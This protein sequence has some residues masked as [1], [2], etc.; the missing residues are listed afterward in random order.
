VSV[1]KP[2]QLTKFSIVSGLRT[3]FFPELIRTSLEIIHVL[4]IHFPEAPTEVNTC[5]QRI[6]V[7]EE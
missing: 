5:M 1:M 3:M 2:M 4:Q 7:Y 6:Y